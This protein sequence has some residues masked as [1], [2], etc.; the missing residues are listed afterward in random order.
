MKC[1]YRPFLV[2]KKRRV[3]MVRLKRMAAGLA[4][5][6][7]LASSAA[8]PALAYE[9]SGALSESDGASARSFLQLQEDVGFRVV[10]Y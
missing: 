7:V 6:V 2:S 8:T 10:W 3:E 9:V 5:G 1:V 4:L